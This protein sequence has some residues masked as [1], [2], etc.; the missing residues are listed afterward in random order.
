MD[1]TK[2]SK[3]LLSK[4]ISPS[5]LTLGFIG[6]GNIG[7][8]IVKNLLNSGHKVIIWNR[9]TEKVIHFLFYLNIF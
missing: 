7:S 2:I 5:N 6:L 4:N 1:V 9:T 3:S 8:G